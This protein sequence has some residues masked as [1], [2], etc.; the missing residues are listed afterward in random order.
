MNAVFA[1]AVGALF[2]IGVYQLLGKDLI[3][4][5][6][7]IY[8]LFNGLN[9]LIMAMGTVPGRNAPFAQLGGPFVDPLVQAMVLTAIVIGFGLA[10]FLLVLAARLGQKRQSLDAEEMT[11]WKH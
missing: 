3:R 10:T 9:I 7:G 1:L 5:V 6:F 4:I 8:I 11:R 2:F